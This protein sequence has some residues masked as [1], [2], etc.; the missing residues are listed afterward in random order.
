M[1]HAVKYHKQWNVAEH[2]AKRLLRQERAQ[3][4]LDEVDL[5]V[6]VPMHWWRQVLRGFNQAEVIARTLARPF[7][8]PVVSAVTR[9]TNT[10]SQ[11][12]FDSRAA[13]ARNVKDCF[14]LDRPD[15]IAG[16]RVLVVDDVMTTGATLRAVAMCLGDAEPESIDAMVIAS[17]SPSHSSTA[18]VKLK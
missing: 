16:K 6:P 12:G 1:I 15:L 7:R 3:K 2:L 5:V 13:R 8:L 9:V 11:T 10:P 17:V 18:P 14:R 4:L